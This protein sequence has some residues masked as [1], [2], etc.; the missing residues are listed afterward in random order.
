MGLFYAPLVPTHN[1]LRVI[2]HYNSYIKATGYIVSKYP[3]RHVCNHRL[4]NEGK[5]GNK[6]VKHIFLLCFYSP[7]LLWSSAMPVT[8]DNRSQCLLIIVLLNLTEF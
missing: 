1:K 2:A 8:E 4:N 6:K 3:L 7:V 5:E